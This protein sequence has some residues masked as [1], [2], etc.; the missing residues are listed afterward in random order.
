MCP[1]SPAKWNVVNVIP[2]GFRVF[3]DEL[4]DFQKI[5]ALA[6]HSRNCQI[7]HRVFVRLHWVDPPNRISPFSEMARRRPPV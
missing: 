4:R 3:D 1:L 7:V 6:D 5:L 2:V